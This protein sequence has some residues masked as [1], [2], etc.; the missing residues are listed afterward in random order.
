[1]G[2]MFQGKA[3]ILISWAW[4]LTCAAAEREYFIPSQNL[5]WVEARSHCQVCYKDLVS[6]TPENIQIVA[7]ML[8][9]EHWIGLRKYFPDISHSDGSPWIQWANGDLVIFQNWHPGMPMSKV[10][11]PRIDCCSCSCTCPASSG[12]IL[13]TV[14]TT[15]PL[16]N[17]SSMASQ[18]TKALPLNATC[19]RAPI[20]PPVVP[21]TNKLYIEDS[22]VVMLRHGLWA[23][24]NCTDERPFICYEDKFFGHVDVN[25]N[26]SN[27]ASLKWQPGPGDISLYEVEVK[28]EP[29]L[30][31]NLTDLSHTLTGLIGGNYYEVAVSALK[32]SRF[33]NPQRASFYTVPHKVKDLRVDNTTASS[34]SLSWNEPDGN[35]SLYLVQTV[36]HRREVNTT[37]LEFEG[38]TPGSC[39]TFMVQSG[40]QDRS[41]W[42]ER[43]MIA[44]CTKPGK[45]SNL[46]AV[47]ITNNKLTLKW[48]APDGNFAGFS[49][50]VTIRNSDKYLTAT[51]IETQI[52]ITN[53]PSGSNITL[54]VRVKA[55]H[56]V[57]GDAVSIIA[58]TVPDPVWDLT[59][60]PGNKQLTAKWNYSETADVTFTAEVWKDKQFIQK[61]TTLENKEITFGDLKSATNYTVY[62]YAVSGTHTGV[63]VSTSEFTLPASPQNLRSPFN[64]TDKI[65][66]EWDAPDGITEAIY[67]INFTSIWSQSSK[68]EVKDITSHNFTNLKSG[69]RYFF[70][71]YS[72]AGEFTSL[73]TS[74]NVSTVPVKTDLSLSMLCSSAQSL[75]CA[76]DNQKKGVFIK[77]QEH[78]NKKLG[79]A[80]FWELEI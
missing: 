41:Q 5:S 64:S 8:K 38:L 76:D 36:D 44:N 11:L 66:L 55:N 18:V 9:S 47:D 49:I 50:K 71:V 34:I 30:K 61:F 25:C 12:S 16:M 42:S 39:F 72:R 63:N 69:T 46:E 28:G 62:V 56:D 13:P 68:V 33:L 51:K 17:F 35:A 14:L 58:Y 21:E 45:V 2:V 19:E 3:W 54:E 20:V 22:C 78:F 23:E 52:I 26:M 57:M 48:K 32:C 27:S 77:L 65:T 74:Y 43:S 59:L 75:L 1:M 24:R 37:G 10:P 4:L 67:I 6:M 80:V 60:V 70:Q 73:P 40:V 29:P 53:L 31:L 15:E 79:N 7:P